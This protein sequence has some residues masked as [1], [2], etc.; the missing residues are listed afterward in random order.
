MVIN[1]SHLYKLIVELISQNGTKSSFIEI[2]DLLYLSDASANRFRSGYFS[3]KNKQAWWPD[4][5]DW[6]CYALENG[7]PISE[8]SDQK[9]KCCDSILS[10]EEEWKSIIKHLREKSNECAFPDMKSAYDKMINQCQAY[11]KAYPL[12][13]EDYVFYELTELYKGIGFSISKL[14]TILRNIL[15]NVPEV[16]EIVAY[17]TADEKFKR[18]IDKCLHNRQTDLERENSKDL[19]AQ[20]S[21]PN[22][23]YDLAVSFI[24]DTPFHETHYPHLEFDD[25]VDYMETSATGLKMSKTDMTNLVV[26]CIDNKEFH[27]YANDLCEIALSCYPLD[28]KLLG[29]GIKA[30]L[31]LVD[32]D[33][34]SEYAKRANTLPQINSAVLLQQLMNYYSSILYIYPNKKHGAEKRHFTKTINRYIELYPNDENPFLDIAAQLINEG[35]PAK[36]TRLLKDVIKVSNSCAGCCC[37]LIQYILSNYANKLQP[38]IER[39]IIR[40]A[41]KGL[42]KPT[43]T[44]FLNL[45]YLHEQ[46]AEMKL[47]LYQS[48]QINPPDNITPKNI[49]N[50]YK[51]AFSYYRYV[52]SDLTDIAKEKYLDS[53]HLIRRRCLILKEE[54]EEFSFIDPTDFTFE[55]RLNSLFI[56]ILYP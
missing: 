40:I 27:D 49:Y 3:S 2:A 51:K 31:L 44:T 22:K 55:N 13:F 11:I 48:N 41:Q 6:F 20:I 42:S 23:L 37:T 39:Q 10:K 38:R 4:S 17:K 1:S 45:A 30:A 28:Q 43:H 26:A 46:S 19:L 24:H 29:C 34:A 25:V 12:K 52:Y 47:N 56:Y 18:L 33:T 35:H 5:T 15:T 9:K 21:S 53:I 14:N 8:L 36:A 50:E 54:Y 32:M 7:C 16:N